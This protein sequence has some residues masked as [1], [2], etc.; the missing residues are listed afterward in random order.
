MRFTAICLYV[1]LSLLVSVLCASE[2]MESAPVIEAAE[3][4]WAEHESNAYAPKHGGPFLAGSYV[5][6]GRADRAYKAFQQ[7][8]LKLKAG[9]QGAEGLR[10][11]IT[12]LDAEMKVQQ[13]FRKKPAPWQAVNAL[14]ANGNIH[15]SYALNCAKIYAYDVALKWEGGEQLYFAANPFMLPIDK[16]A[17]KHQAFLVTSNPD[18]KYKRSRK[19][20]TVTFHISNLGGKAAEEVENTI[21]FVDDEGKEVHSEIFQPNGGTVDPGFSGPQKAE[22]KKIPKFDNVTIKTRQSESLTYSWEGDEAVLAEDIMLRKLRYTE[23]AL[24]GT[25]INGFKDEISNLV[26]T[27]TFDNAGDEAFKTLDVKIAKIAS[28]EEIQFAEKMEA[29]TFTGYSMGYSF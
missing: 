25:V 12:P 16:S 4:R 10:I 17:L 20:A 15:V 23:E 27:I 9:A 28:G 22:F 8:E 14:Q 21:V 18:F 29:F 24:T 6:G 19:K 5:W 26:L 2:P 13:L 1:S 7:W 3:K 11:Q